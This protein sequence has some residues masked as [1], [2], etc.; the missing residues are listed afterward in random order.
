M[1]DKSKVPAVYSVLPSIGGWGFLWKKLPTG[2]AK[3]VLVITSANGRNQTPST[4]MEVL[5]LEVANDKWPFVFLV[6]HEDAL[7]GHPQDRLYGLRLDV[8][9][10]SYA[11]S[12]SCKGKGLEVDEDPTI[13]HANLNL[14]WGIMLEAQHESAVAAE[15]PPPNNVTPT[16][17]RK[18]PVK[19]RTDRSKAPAGKKSK[20]DTKKE[21]TIEEAVTYTDKDK[22]LLTAER[23]EEIRV[24]YDKVFSPLYIHRQALG[25]GTG[26]FQRPPGTDL[27]VNYSKLHLAEAGK[28]VYRGLVLDRLKHLM[29]AIDIVPDISLVRAQVVVLPLKAFGN[30]GTPVYFDRAPVESEITADTHFFIIGGQHTVEAHKKIVL[31]PK[32]ISDLKKNLL[33]NFAIIPVWCHQSNHK[34]LLY[35]S[36]VLNQDVAGERTEQTY[37]EQLSNARVAWTDCGKPPPA[38]CGRV[39]SD[40]F[41][42]RSFSSPKITHYCRFTGFRISCPASGDPP[43]P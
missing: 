5:H 40:K 29:M 7:L 35:L 26:A 42:V 24:L 10:L 21:L 16:K 41:K 18:S 12:D 34:L 37:I 23:R 11:L 14:G 13:T 27:L 32:H 2:R 20:A 4:G 6:V 15:E 38:L 39:H 3:I 8:R 31:G 28:M 33:S 19:L 30:K 43:M 9:K 25:A 17:K 36:R 22:K 1:P